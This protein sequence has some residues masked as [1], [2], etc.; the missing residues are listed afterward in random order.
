MDR[1]R[2]SKGA[3]ADDQEAAQIAGVGVF[4]EAKFR[5]PCEARAERAKQYPSC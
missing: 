5:M 2:Y 1:D 4:G 3:Y